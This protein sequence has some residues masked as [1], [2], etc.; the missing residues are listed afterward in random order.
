[1]D[2]WGEMPFYQ[3]DLW[4]LRAAFAGVFTA[5]RVAQAAFRT[6][7]V[8]AHILC[9]EPLFH[10]NVE[11]TLN[12]LRKQSR[13]VLIVDFWRTAPPKQR[14][15]FGLTALLFSSSHAVSREQ[16]R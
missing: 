15:M 6:A 11:S 3:L 16:A 2:Y 9:A 10:S 8:P 5:S 13:L 7:S 14:H 4:E 1:M 12:L